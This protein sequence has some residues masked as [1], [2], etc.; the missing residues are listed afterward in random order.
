MARKGSAKIALADQALR[1]GPGPAAQ[2][3]LSIERVIE[4]AK[5]SGAQAIHPGYGFLSENRAFAEAC[6]T[7]GIFRKCAA[8]RFA[9]CRWCV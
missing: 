7:S 6:T 4:A 9:V 1:L 8:A 3:Y 2:S 5:A